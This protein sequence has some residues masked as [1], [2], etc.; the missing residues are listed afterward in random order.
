GADGADVVECVGA[1]RMACELR[2]LPR[3]EARENARGELP[4]LRLQASD[5]LLDVDLGLRG[6]VLELLDFRFELGDRLF[7]IQESNG[8]ERFYRKFKCCA[9]VRGAAPGRKVRVAGRRAGLF[10][11]G[12]A[13]ERIA[14]RRRDAV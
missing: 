11:A 13:P 14:S 3:R 4:A 2:D 9:R 12:P 1:V 10:A 6:D 5:F 8:H 7:E